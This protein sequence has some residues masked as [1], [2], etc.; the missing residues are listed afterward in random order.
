MKL[1]SSAVSFNSLWS[2]FHKESM[3]WDQTLIFKWNMIKCRSAWVGLPCSFVGNSAWTRFVTSFPFPV[4][5]SLSFFPC[6][7]FCLVKQGF[8]RIHYCLARRWR[9][10]CS[11]WNLMIKSFSHPSNNCKCVWKRIPMASS[12]CYWVHT[13]R[14]RLEIVWWIMKQCSMPECTDWAGILTVH[15][16]VCCSQFSGRCSLCCV[17]VIPYLFIEL[18][19]GPR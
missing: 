18:L 16:W 14:Y 5:P 15:V 4:L 19:C 11:C 13:P 2:A 12:S 1:Q 7:E 9:N 17:T 6:E 10:R 8:V 3:E